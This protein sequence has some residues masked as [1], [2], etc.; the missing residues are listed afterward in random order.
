M[1]QNVLVAVPYRERPEMAF[2][3]DTLLPLANAGASSIVA[4]RMFND[5]LS[6]IIYSD[7]LKKHY[8]PLHGLTVTVSKY[9]MNDLP[10]ISTARNLLGKACLSRNAEWIYWLDADMVQQY[11][12]DPVVALRMLIDTAIRENVDMVSGMYLSKKD[13]RLCAYMWDP[14]VTQRSIPKRVVPPS[15]C[16]VDAVGFGC[17][18]MSTRVLRRISYPWF[19]SDSD[20]D[21]GEDTGFCRRAGDVGLKIWLHGEVCFSH[22]GLQSLSVLEDERE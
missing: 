12:K 18:L 10:H 3:T 17:L 21:Y 20:L 11:P 16:L 1:N 7:D 14:E 13:R 4:N 15:G 5:G 19:V 6:D 8:D 9:L 2:I 22:V